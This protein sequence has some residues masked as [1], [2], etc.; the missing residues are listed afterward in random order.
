MTTLELQNTIIRKILETDDSVL[1]DFVNTILAGNRKLNEYQFTETER[2]LIQE[3]Q[4]SY[5]AGE[6]IDDDVVIDR[7]DKWLEK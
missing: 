5:M 6:T 2:K 3:S 7:L 1:L 4:S